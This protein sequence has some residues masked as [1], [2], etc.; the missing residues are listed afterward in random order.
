MEV[1]Q[2]LLLIIG[3]VALLVPLSSNGAPTV[4]VKPATS[5]KLAASV[6]ATAP[7]KPASAASTNCTGKTQEDAIHMNSI[8]FWRLIANQP[9][10][11]YFMDTQKCFTPSQ[12]VSLFETKTDDGGVYWRTA[13]GTVLVRKVEPI[14]YAEYKK[15]ERT[16]T[17]GKELES[18]RK[19]LIEFTGKKEPE[20]DSVSVNAVTVV[21][22]K[23]EDSLKTYGS[24]R[25]HP[26]GKSL[27]KKEFVEEMKKGHVYDIRPEAMAKKVPLKYVK[28][29]TYA[30]YSFVT[31]DV[32][33]PEQ[34]KKKKVR[35]KAPPLPKNKNEPI[36]II[37]GC[38]GE[39]SGY[40][41]VTLLT[42]MGYKNVG[43]YPGGMSEY[44]KT[45]HPCIT[46]DKPSDATIVD[47][48]RVK[49][50]IDN[51]NTVILDT[52]SGGAFTL[53]KAK[54]KPFPEKRNGLSMPLYREGVTVTGL[55]AKK[56][57]Y[58]KDVNFPKGK[59]ILVVGENEYDWRGYKATIYLKSKGYQNVYWYRSGMRD[60][61]QKVL[62]H[63][64][65]Y[66]INKKVTN[67]ELY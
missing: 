36:Y 17:L 58:K 13:R 61:A 40:N 3:T 28:K 15:R 42:E 6:P 45:H 51:K 62:I 48:K 23:I 49:E 53:P 33:S 50:L 20:L 57:F 7:I 59:T 64:N 34:M 31:M 2:K 63:P 19:K 24:P 16:T 55:T 67:G 38:P 10:T 1:S 11:L 46:P 4:P 43:W 21:A 18:F 41:T 25:I 27:K 56:E 66:K 37:G 60:W 8:K 35:F 44:G 39:F 32:M 52:R 5:E 9:V 65:E 22:D 29:L 54:F 47:A 26:S 12:K 30:D 14:T